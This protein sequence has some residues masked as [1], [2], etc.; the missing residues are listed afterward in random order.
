MDLKLSVKLSTTGIG[1]KAAE[2]LK[3]SIHKSVAIDVVKER[4]TTKLKSSSPT[5]IQYSD[6]IDENQQAIGTEVK[7][8]IPIL[9]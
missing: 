2:S 8:F 3:T 1:R 9:N 7:I 6:L 5:P 4:L